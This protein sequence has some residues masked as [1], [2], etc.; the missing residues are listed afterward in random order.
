MLAV[1]LGFQWR[2]NFFHY[3][4]K[5]SNKKLEIQILNLISK[6]DYRELFNQIDIYPDIGKERV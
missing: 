2:Y 1:I 5:K 3:T 6:R 4:D